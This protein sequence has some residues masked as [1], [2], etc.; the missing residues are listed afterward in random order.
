MLVPGILNSTTFMS[1]QFRDN[2]RL[3][4]GLYPLSLQNQWN[5]RGTKLT[6]E[7]VLQLWNGRLNRLDNIDGAY[8]WD[9]IFTDTQKPNDADNEPILNYDGWM[10]E[11]L[12][13]GVDI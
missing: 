12:G 4:L 8:E 2:L 10:E 9:L 6:L 13:E 1:K 7:H 3:N 5:G 11:G